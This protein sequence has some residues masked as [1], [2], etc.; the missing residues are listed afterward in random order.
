MDTVV[1]S[2]VSFRPVIVCRGEPQA[3]VRIQKQSL[4]EA[5]LLSGR[6]RLDSPAR[7][8]PV[9]FNWSASEHQS[10]L[11]WTARTLG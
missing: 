2:P 11:F 5:K 8:L 9:S 3:R 7:E 10:G 4:D 1:V 6:I